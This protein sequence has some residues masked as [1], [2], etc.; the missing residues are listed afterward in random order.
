M[1]WKVVSGPGSVGDPSSAERAK[2]AEEKRKFQAGLEPLTRQLANARPYEAAAARKAVVDYL[3]ASRTKY[4]ASL[5]K[6]DEIDRTYHPPA[7]VTTK[8]RVTLRGTAADGRTVDVS[9]DVVP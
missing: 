7:T 5:G 2:H 3:H 6:L 1:T 4:G 8:Q 9:F